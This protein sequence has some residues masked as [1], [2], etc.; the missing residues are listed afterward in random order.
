MK[1]KPNLLF[2]LNGFLIHFSLAYYL[3]SEIDANFFGIVDINSKP[4]NF[5]NH[6]NLLILKKI[7]F[8]IIILI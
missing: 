2:W 6:K 1:T 4:K 8:F 3:Q 7:G 5:L